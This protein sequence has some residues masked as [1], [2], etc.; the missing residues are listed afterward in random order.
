MGLKQRSA[1]ALRTRLE[2]LRPKPEKGSD[3]EGAAPA[4]APREALSRGAAATLPLLRDVAGVLRETLAI[5]VA[6][7]MGAAELAGGLLLAAWRRLVPFAGAGW[8]AAR[9][10][11]AIAQREVTPARATL[12]VVVCALAALA[13]SQFIAYREIAIGVAEYSGIESV[14]P[15][16]GVDRATTGSA[17][18]YLGV[19]LAGVGLVL[20]V[21]AVRGNWR[22]GRP[23]LFVGVAAVAVS[24]LVDL[25]QGLDEGD[26]AIAYES[27][28]ARLLDGFWI[29]LVSGA[30]LMATGPLLA[31]HLRP[32]AGRRARA[33]PAR[34]LRLG[35]TGLSGARARRTAVPPIE[36]TSP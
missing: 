33:R 28:E 27:V 18:G 32:P 23:L 10:A 14:A 13:A 9:H 7:Y 4:F 2:T 36:G 29:Q 17:H 11:I 24:L 34:R 16:P 3:E 30:L 5:L 26:A 8:R 1:S 25:P 22:L 20:A 15:A 35:G 19:P 6:L 21:L 31:E 12:V